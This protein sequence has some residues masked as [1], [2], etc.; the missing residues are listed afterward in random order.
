MNKIIDFIAKVP[1]TNIRIISSI[2]MALGTWVKVLVIGWEPPI[3]WL[4]FL[5]AWA[6]ID[7]AQFA[8]KRATHLTDEGHT[9][10][11]A[12]G[13][14]KRFKDTLVRRDFGEEDGTEPI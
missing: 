14:T 10:W 5:V 12:N 3:V 4:G 2:I 9:V 8:V 11:S 1:T 6:G 7:A 13:N